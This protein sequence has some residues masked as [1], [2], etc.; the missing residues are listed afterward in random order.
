MVDQA[1]GERADDDLVRIGSR[2][3]L[4]GDPDRLAGDEALARIRRGRDD[5]AGL[6][7]D[8]DLEPDLV[9]LRELLVERRDPDADVE[10]GARGTQRVVLVRDGD[11]ERGHDRVARVLLHG[12]AMSRDRR[13]HSLEVAPQDG[14]ERLRIERLRKRHRLDDVDEEDRDE[15]AE[16]HRRPRERRL[17]EEQ[18]LVLAQDRGLELAEL[19]AGVDAE[20][21][22]ERLA[23][24][25]VGG[26]RVGLAARAVEREH[27]LRARAL[28]Q[29]LG[30]DQRLE[31]GDELGVAPEREIRL[32]PLLE[33]DG[34]QLLEPRDLGLGERL[35]EEV[36]ERRAAPERER[37]AQRALGRGGISAFERRPSRP[38]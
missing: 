20:L 34:A 37:L 38:P 28:A 5:L 22:D 33:R 26:E 6:D 32:D 1:P 30:G 3:E 36:G 10:R 11:A 23:R 2:F 19:G 15:P 25:A 24:G 12:A 13:R 29:R 18:R 31:L 8:A 9:L 7:P 27:E 35:V 4:R 16:L 21:L 14:A 17:L